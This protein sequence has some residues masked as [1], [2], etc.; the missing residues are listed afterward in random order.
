MTATIRSSPQDEHLNNFRHH[1]RLFYQRSLS[2]HDSTPQPFP[3]QHQQPHSK[4]DSIANNNDDPAAV[5]KDTQEKSKIVLDALEHHIVNAHSEYVTEEFLEFLTSESVQPH[6]ELLKACGLLPPVSVLHSSSF[7]PLLSS[8]PSSSSSSLG[9]LSSVSKDK[10]SFCKEKPVESDDSKKYSNHTIHDIPISHE[11]LMKYVQIRNEERRYAHDQQ[12]DQ[13]R[14]YL[15]QLIKDLFVTNH[16][17]HV[18]SEKFVKEKE[19]DQNNNIVTTQLFLKNTKQQIQQFVSNYKQNIGTHSFLA[20]MRALMEL[21]LKHDESIILWTFHG[22]TLSEVN[23]S[24]DA[25][26]QDS[27]T[28]SR[29]KTNGGNYIKDAID[30]LK[31]FMIFHENDI[32]ASENGSGQTHETMVS[33]SIHYSIS[34]SFLGHLLSGLP[35]TRDLHTKPAGKL[36]VLDRNMFGVRTNPKGDL[37]EDCWTSWMTMIPWSSSG[38][39]C[40]I[41]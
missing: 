22:S 14:T 20:G 11:I 12:M 16:P 37:D 6:L 40:D 24:F 1:C 41:L 39:H 8:S 35:K 7:Q 15:N 5:T 29:N 28:T 34:N 21:Q 3:L 17:D 9:V 33:F 19:T 18:C 10:D 26:Q 4:K 36:V 31:S 13:R 23:I 38:F 25:T 30:V 27:T 2:I 32:D